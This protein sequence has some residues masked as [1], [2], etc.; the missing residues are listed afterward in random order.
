LIQAVD[1]RGEALN[2]LG[3]VP[4]SI[5]PII[6]WLPSDS[7]W[8]RGLR[9][10]Q[11]LAA[12][13]TKAYINRKNKVKSRKDILSF[14]LN[15]KD[16]QTGKPL[17]EREVI[18]E[19]ISFIVGGS[20]TT[21]TSMTNVVDIV[22]RSAKIQKDLQ[23]ELDTAFPGEMSPNWVAD[24]KI[25]EGLP[26]LNAVLRETMR[27]RPTS[28]TGLER[29]TPEGGRVITGKFLPEGVSTLLKYSTHSENNSSQTLVS[30]PTLNV[31]HS[32]SIFKV[33]IH[34][35]TRLGIC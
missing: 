32:P 28:A 15:A 30:V 21:S 19:S 8:S 35:P 17:S 25:V 1:A 22:S 9:G 34:S 27:F 33:T 11:A 14:L 12:I 5:R 31:H 26:V 7:F 18:A 4:Q 29:V 24:F 10:T 6:K 2:A 23:E 3:H 20:D 16:P 13:G